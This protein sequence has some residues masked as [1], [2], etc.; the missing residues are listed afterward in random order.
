MRRSPEVNGDD[1]R[2]AL[3]GRSSQ[4]RITSPAERRRAASA[5]PTSAPLT[6]TFPRS[7]AAAAFDRDPRRSSVAR[8]LS[9]TRPASCAVTSQT[10]PGSSRPSLLFTFYF[11]LFTYYLIPPAASLRSPLFVT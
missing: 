2:L 6:K 8:N 7:R 3:P 4:T 11:S 1:R 5:R 10:L 9:T